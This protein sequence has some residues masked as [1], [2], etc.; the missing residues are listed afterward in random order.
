[1]FRVAV[2]LSVAQFRDPRLIDRIGEAVRDSRIDPHCLEL[3]I[4]E[5]VAM[6]GETRLVET[7][8]VLRGLGLQLAI[9][10]FGT[11]YSSLAYLQRM[12]VDRLKIDRSFIAQLGREQRAGT[13]AEMVVQL[14]RTLGLRVIA[15]G[16]EDENQAA[17]LRALGC[18]EAQ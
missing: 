3:E 11:G 13:I 7:F 17:G 8:A 9:D 14:G 1:D 6:T 18:H 2:N 15:E 10:D 12:R 4:T 16:V 5:S